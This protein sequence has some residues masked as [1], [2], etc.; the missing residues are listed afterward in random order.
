VLG[1]LDGLSW[2]RGAEKEEERRNL[3][4]KSFPFSKTLKP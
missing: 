4:E 1:R 2:C 3:K